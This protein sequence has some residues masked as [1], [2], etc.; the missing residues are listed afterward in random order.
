MA[1]RGRGG[2]VS[3][4]D[5]VGRLSDRPAL[6]RA[7]TR[8]RGR[9]DHDRFVG[10][11]LL[12]P[13]VA[14]ILGRTVYPI[15]QVLQL[16]LHQQGPVSRETTFVGR[17]NSQ[18][19]LAPEAFT[20]SVK[21]S[22]VFAFGSLSL[23]IAPSPFGSPDW[24]MA[25]VILVNT[26]KNFPFMVLV[27]LAQLQTIDQKPC[28]AAAVTGASGSQQFGDSTLP[29]LI[30][31]VLVMGMLRTIWNF[32]DFEVVVL[33]TRGGPTGRTETLPLLIY[34]FDVTCPAARFA[35][36]QFCNGGGIDPEACAIR[37]TGAVSP[38]V[39]VA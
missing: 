35:Y 20:R 14:L 33:L 21:D 10:F 25:G 39:S 37:E 32:N 15:G 12:L 36:N 18:T 5:L 8:P 28:E 17:Q 4:G 31:I 26:W 19:V 6:A 1:A 9:R 13:L 27:F 24:S 29:S 30:P 16:S 2:G 23:P 38:F 11:L 7:P 3:T 34:G 22:S